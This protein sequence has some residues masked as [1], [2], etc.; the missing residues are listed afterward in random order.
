MCLSI[1]LA[2]VLGCYLVLISLSMLI[3]QVMFKKMIQ[4]FLM[5]PALI[6]LSGSLT[7]MSGLLILVPHN[8]WIAQWPVVVTLIGW[9]FF[10]KG[11]MR[12][13]FPQNYIKLVK[14]LLERKG[15]LLVS[16]I[17]FLIGLYLLWAGFTQ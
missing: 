1:F 17:W 7:L 3:H 9:F 16:W 4:D 2:Q 6:V 14:Y 5:N 10:L 15:F 8:L 12:L 11:I 13:F